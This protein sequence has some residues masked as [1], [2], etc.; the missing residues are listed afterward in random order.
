MK[1]VSIDYIIPVFN[2]DNFLEETLRSI[3]NQDDTGLDLEVEIRAI[4]VDDGSWD[5]TS[6]VAHKLRMEF[7]SRIDYFFQENSGESSAVNNGFLNSKSEYLC[8]LSSDDLVAKDHALV[9]CSTLEKQRQCV[10][11][12]CHWNR[13]DKTGQV[14][15]RVRVRSFSLDKLWNQFICIPGPGAVIRRSLV[16]RSE[17]RSG[18]YRFIDD[19]EQW[20]SLSKHGDFVKVNKFLASWRTHFNQA[21]S[22]KNALFI[23]KEMYGLAS[24]MQKDKQNIPEIDSGRIMLHVGYRLDL[25]K[26]QFSISDEDLTFIRFPRVRLQTK[27]G[28]RLLCE[29]PIAFLRYKIAMRRNIN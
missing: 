27:D 23:S 2:G 29:D 28:L 18:L 5:N 6:D 15:R 24:E 19:Y 1:K 14:L 20:L 10:V 9:M 7:P 13:I 4:V 17:I 22:A 25:R 16:S 12:Y 11:A 21:T 8:I 26:I 3:M